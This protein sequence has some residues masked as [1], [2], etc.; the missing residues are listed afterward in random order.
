MRV[1]VKKDIVAAIRRRMTVPLSFVEAG[2]IDYEISIIKVTKISHKLKVGQLPRNRFKLQIQVQKHGDLDA[3]LRFI[4]QNGVS[5]FSGIQRF[6]PKGK[7]MSASR[8]LVYCDP[9]GTHRLHPRNGMA[10]SS[11]RLADFDAIAG[12]RVQKGSWLQFE[13]NDAVILNGRVIHFQVKTDEMIQTIDRIDQDELNPTALLAGRQIKTSVK[14]SKNEQKIISE[15]CVLDSWLKS[16][17]GYEESRSVRLQPKNLEWLWNYS[18]SNLSLILPKGV[19]A[20]TLFNKLGDF[21][22]SHA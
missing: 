16:L 5:N 2:Y 17:P 4:A 7:N 21:K 8:R 9:C 1:R 10:T 11:A 13:S 18:G 22:E 19:F 12:R 15:D 3:R 14:Q 6:R 20:T